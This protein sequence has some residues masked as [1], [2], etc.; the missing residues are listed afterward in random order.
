MSATAI[1]ACQGMGTG[2]GSLPADL[3]C[4]FVFAR[5]TSPWT[6]KIMGIPSIGERKSLTVDD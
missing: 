2:A 1:A 5:T 6:D 4:R 3:N